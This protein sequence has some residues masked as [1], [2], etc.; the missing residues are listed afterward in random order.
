MAKTVDA[1]RNVWLYYP[2]FV[3]TTSHLDLDSSSMIL[4]TSCVN[5]VWRMLLI[6]SKLRRYSLYITWFTHPITK[7]CN[8]G[9]K[10]FISLWIAWTIDKWLADK[11]FSCI[12]AR[13]EEFDDVLNPWDTSY[14]ERILLEKEYSLDQEK[15]KKYFSLETTIQ[16]EWK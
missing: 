12:A 14:Y 6:W 1:V 9:R 7:T 13:G 15:I 3:R 4:P 16:S 2:V 11:I 8:I 10:R 5:L